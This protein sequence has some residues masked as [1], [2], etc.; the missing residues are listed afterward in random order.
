MKMRYLLCVMCTML[1]TS[2]SMRADETITVSSTGSD[3]SEN[4]DLKAVATLFGEVNDLGK[5][6]EELNS[7]KRHINNLDLNGDGIVDY[8]RV[9]EVKDGNKHLVVIQAILA[10]DIYQDVATIYVEKAKDNKVTVQI[11]GDEYIYG[12]NYVIEPVYFYRPV[13]YDWFWGAHWVC[14]HS[15][16]YWGYYPHYWGHYHCW[17][18]HDYWMHMHYYHHHHAHCSY[19]YAHA[20]RHSVGVMRKHV[21][22]NDYAVAHPNRSFAARNASRNIQNARPLQQ[23]RDV[24]LRSVQATG[25]HRTTQA[26]NDANVR[27]RADLKTSTNATTAS[28]LT[29]TNG[30]NVA[31]ART[32]GSSNVRRTN[33]A[34]LSDANVSRQQVTNTTSNATRVTSGRT[35][36]TAKATTVTTSRPQSTTST[37]KRSDA[38]RVVDNSQR[39]NYRS[40]TSVNTSN[41]TS[42]YGSSSSTS[43]SSSGSSTR[44]SSGMSRPSSTFGGGSR[45]TGTSVGGSRTSTATRR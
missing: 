4:L 10:K 35:T 8:L 26:G 16:Y 44:V 37:A 9:V 38:T 13:I 36:G 15:P 28:R 20:P 12:V 3:I 31:S 33:N 32:F 39:T 22:R 7:E 1:L 43:R 5:F 11:V 42:Q 25:T 29:T 19:R 30:T 24:D 2:I 45:S 40:S 6:E 18:A 41:R 14:W 21:S 23:K 17:Y 27:Q 34:T